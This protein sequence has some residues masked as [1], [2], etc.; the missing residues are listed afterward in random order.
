[1]ICLG[2][3]STSHTFGVGIVDGDGKILSDA[4]DVFVPKPGKGFVPKEL[5]D[6][7]IEV[8]FKVIYEALKKSGLKIR[9]ID[10]ISFSQGPGIPN[11]LRVGAAVARFLSIKLKK[12]L[13]GV[14]HPVA[15][16]EIGKLN[17]GS[18]DPIVV[19]LSGGNTQIIAHVEGRYR[20]FGETQDI[21]VGNCF[22]VVA[23]EIG[24]P[25]PGGPN[26]EKFAKSG[27]YVELP[28]VVKGMD[29]SFSGIATAAIKKF[30][31]GVRREDICY[32]L[33]ETCFA[34]LTEVTERALAHTEKNEVLLVGGVAANKRLQEMMKQMCEDRDA[35]FFVVDE[36]FSG[37]N[38][39]MIACTGL[40]QYMSEKKS[41]KDTSIRQNWRTD[42]VKTTWIRSVRFRSR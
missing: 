11:S 5:A 30:K 36:K 41:T 33:Q 18:K 1:M 26:V 19:Y 15:H 21:P 17:T 4:R 32:S 28:Y 8:A 12:P 38:G 2:I 13:V 3:E 10:L 22:D 6:H 42:E 24:L 39:T 16:I 35:R 34:I 27:N 25:A 7:H 40:L 31:A 23:R 29:Q 14:N 9:D 20:I 37:D